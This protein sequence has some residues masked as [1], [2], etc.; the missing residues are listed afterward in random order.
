MTERAFS[1]R[2]GT[3]ERLRKDPD[4]IGHARERRLFYFSDEIWEFMLD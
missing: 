4:V 3:M 1:E 2:I